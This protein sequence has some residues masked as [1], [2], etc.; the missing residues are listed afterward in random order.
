[1]DNNLHAKE[2]L[3]QLTAKGEISFTSQKMRLDLGMTTKA[4]ERAIY[5]LKRKKEITAIAKG[6]YLILK[7]R[8]FRKLGCLP[9]DY[10]IDDLMR[11]WQQDYYVGLLSAALYFGA[12]HQQPQI[13]QIVIDQY[14]HAIRCGQVKIEFITKEKLSAAQ[15]KKLKTHTGSINISTP[16]T[17]MMDLCVFMRRSGGLSHVATVLNELAESVDAIALKK[18]L[19]KT[20]E[21]TWVQRLGYLLE[22]LGHHELAA[23]IY[24]HIKHQR[25]NIV[26]L[27]PYSSI[28][29]VERNTKWRV[30]INAVVESDIDDTD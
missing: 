5:R 17:T 26:P 25:T 15:T 24:Q 28:T 6:F 1:M 16:E 21:F 2:Y 22:N 11:F 4:V 14:R 23:V 29:G 18:L 13:F 10:F 27:V 7:L 30:A 9:P 19:K 3:D 8:K 20:K 12:A